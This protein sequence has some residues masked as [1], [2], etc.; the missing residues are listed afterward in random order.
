[1]PASVPEGN[2]AVAAAT[3]LA[4]LESGPYSDTELPAAE[5]ALK[6]ALPASASW[7]VQNG[8]RPGVWLIYMG[9]Y[10]NREALDKKVGE[11]KAFGIQSEPVRS[12]PELEPG[13]SL[14]RFE[15]RAMADERLA[16][17]AKRGVRTARVINITPPTATH[18]LRFA[19][20]DAPTQRALTALKDKLPGEKG[21]GPC[22]SGA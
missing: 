20:A 17:F 18:T 2:S 1:V 14:G 15:D 9:K 11:L 7:A 12:S 16:E 10:A 8:E 22:S 3:T 21:F 19:Q 4:C 5:S 6:A 13:L